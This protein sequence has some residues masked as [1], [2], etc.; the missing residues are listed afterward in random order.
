M[1]DET[2]GEPQEEESLRPDI[3]A[4]A[5]TIGG[6]VGG[7]SAA[8]NGRK[9]QLGIKDGGGGDTTT[10]VSAAYQDDV[11]IG[12]GMDIAIQGENGKLELP[13]LFKIVSAEPLLS[14]VDRLLEASN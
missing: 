11:K 7:A 10:T 8:H 14:P 1:P 5:D 13:I 2:G 12:D 3:A 9:R 6:S 4:L